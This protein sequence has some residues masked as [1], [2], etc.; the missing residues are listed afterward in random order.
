MGLSASL[1]PPGW[2]C[3]PV[4]S[5][6][7]S[8]HLSFSSFRHIFNMLMEMEQ[9][10]GSSSTFVWWLWTVVSMGHLAS[11]LKI[12][13]KVWWS[14][15]MSAPRASHKCWSL[16]AQV[17]YQILQSHALNYSFRMRIHLEP[18][19][20]GSKRTLRTCTQGSSSIQS[21][22]CKIC[23]YLAISRRFCL[24]MSSTINLLRSSVV[25]SEIFW[26][27][28]WSTR[29]T[30]FQ[31]KIQSMKLFNH[32][33]TKNLR[34]NFMSFVSR[35]STLLRL[36]FYQRV[37]NTTRSR[38]NIW[39]TP[40]VASC[41]SSLLDLSALTLMNLFTRDAWLS[42]PTP[43]WMMP[44]D[45]VRFLL[46]MAWSILSQRKSLQQDCQTMFWTWLRRLFK[47]LRLP[48]TGSTSAAGEW[49]LVLFRTSLLVSVHKQSPRLKESW[50]S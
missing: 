32:V 38:E 41:R 5:V 13:S 35:S 42:S 30:S 45:K 49:P 24:R 7:N 39:W 36:K 25:E 2:A 47:M 22:P 37:V 50:L 46:S 29:D 8:F 16:Q 23:L 10:T 28:I 4:S 33:L 21:K 11:S 27:Q 43:A 1:A 12:V 18:S 20:L 44:W 9:W 40:W 17:W 26:R 6:M 34:I 31:S 19:G 15:S 14:G 3:W 48:V